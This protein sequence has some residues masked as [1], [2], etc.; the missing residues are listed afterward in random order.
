MCHTEYGESQ[1]GMSQL[2]EAVARYH[3]LLE[4]DSFRDLTWAE[5]LHEEMRLRDL[6]VSG[7]P[8]SPVVRPHFVTRRQY[9][10]L[11][12]AAES[13]FGAI[14]RMERVALSR[15]AL[16]SRMALLPAEKMLASIDPGYSVS[17]VT[18]LL[19]TSLHNGTMQFL[20]YTADPP[21]GLAQTD[22]LSDVFF[23][24]GP[25]QEMRKRYS[26]SKVEASQNLLDA[27]LQAWREFGGQRP[28]RIAVLE[29]RPPFQ[30]KPS[31]E[32]MLLADTFRR[33]GYAAEVVAPDHL[34]YRNGVLRQG[35][36]AIDLVYRRLK[37]HE[38][39]VRFDLT[40]PLV[41]A[42]RDRATCVVNS[43]RSELAQKKAIF[44]LLTDEAVTA[45]F[46]LVERKAIRDFVPWTRMVA[47]AKTTYHDQTVDLPEFIRTNRERLVLR[48]N[49]DASEQMS[50]TGSQTDD[51]SWD[52]AIRTAL[53]NSYVVQEAVEPVSELF[54]LYRYGQLELKKMRVDVLPHAFLGK[55]QGCT[56][57]VTAAGP[58]S[59]S[60]LAGIVPTFILEGKT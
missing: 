26:I 40:H 3:R 41:R 54:P 20:E 36:F 60:M 30:A 59:F 52:R 10:A 32:H 18:G 5:R 58:A 50:F 19:D 43:F 17:A 55:V 31:E 12:R 16:L 27:L 57:Y 15:P 22:S 42:Y 46:P 44:D 33:A 24:C 53:R 56:S 2:N 1:R 47:A 9:T 48:P 29:F 21:L 4:S 8:I 6:M 51:V 14:D 35:D 13:L 7:R 37:V 38:F 23:D 34:E 25:M 45:D 28:P 39:L 11:V 49:D